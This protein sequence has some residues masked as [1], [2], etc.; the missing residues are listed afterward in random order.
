MRQRTAA[1]PPYQICMK[2][3]K[4]RV[5]SPL[6]GFLRIIRTHCA[7]R[8]FGAP[9]THDPLHHMYIRMI[10][11]AYARVTR[12]TSA[13]THMHIHKR[14]CMRARQENFNVFPCAPCARLA[15]RNPAIPLAETI[16]PALTLRAF[17]AFRPVLLPIFLS[18]EIRDVTKFH[19][20]EIAATANFG[21]VAAIFRR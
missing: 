1:S 9:R 14:V 10:A 21:R 5:E 12:G 8:R 17:A 7:A 16:F 6:R 19:Y 20:D 11:H 4:A 15:E 18:S 13:Y 3:R 2:S